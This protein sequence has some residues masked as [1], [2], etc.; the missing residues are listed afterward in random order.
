MSQELLTFLKSKAGIGAPDPSIMDVGLK[1]ARAV[2]VTK[3]YCY[4]D[5]GRGLVLG[6]RAVWS[7]QPKVVHDLFQHH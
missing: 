6:W 3:F 5:V 4:R 7:F 2:A 1:L